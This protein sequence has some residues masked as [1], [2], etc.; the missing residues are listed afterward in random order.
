MS[1]LPVYVGLDYHEDWIRV[2][3]VDEEGRELV[4]RDRPND[5]EM[6]AEFIWGHGTPDSVALEACGGSA[7]FAHALAQA[8]P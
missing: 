2:C 1:I 3:I 7:S 6:V 5:V 8:Y 4:N